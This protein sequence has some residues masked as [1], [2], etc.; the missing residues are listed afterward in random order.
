MVIYHINQLY[1]E[2][3]NLGITAAA[4]PAVHVDGLSAKLEELQ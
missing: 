2:I 4:I 3:N 1:A